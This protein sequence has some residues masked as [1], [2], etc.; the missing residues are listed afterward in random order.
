M[1][2]TRQQ[3]IDKLIELTL[4]QPTDKKDL[5]LATYKRLDFEDYDNEHLELQLAS[6]LQLRERITIENG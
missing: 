1:K 5:L 6:Y 4:D 3:A 2:L